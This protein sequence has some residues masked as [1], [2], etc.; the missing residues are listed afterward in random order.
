MSEDTEHR[1][2][3]DG[4]PTLVFI[5]GSGDTARIWE[6]LIARLPEYTCV[7]LELPGHGALHDRPG[8]DEMSVADYA[9]AVRMEIARRELRGICLIGHSLG[10]AVALRLA[11][12]HPARV[13]RLVL[14]GTGARLRVLPALLE[15]ARTAPETTK[16]QLSELA[17]A[18]GHEGLAEAVAE[19]A[20]PVAAGM[21][22]RDLAAC[23]RFDMM[24]ELGRVAQPTLIVVGEQ[25]RLTPPKYSVF[26]RDQLAAATLV[27]VPMAGHYV[28]REAPEFV[29]QAIRAW[30]PPRVPPL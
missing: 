30:L 28:F 13:G 1:I 25:D 17:F 26:L 2:E 18:P 27:T 11:V 16:R 10:G 5:H 21:L 12:D 6:P 24:A 14:I 22:H 4:M 19:S 7:A 15:G 9:D 8:P 20:Q 23:D 29:A 3:P